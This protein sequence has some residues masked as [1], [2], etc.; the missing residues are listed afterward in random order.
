MNKMFVEKRKI[1]KSLSGPPSLLPPRLSLLA[2]I[3][4]KQSLFLFTKYVCMYLLSSFSNL[5]FFSQ[6]MLADASL[7]NYFLLTGKRKI[8][9]R[10]GFSYRLSL[11]DCQYF[12]VF[13]L[14]FFAFAF[15]LVWA[16]CFGDWQEQEPIQSLWESSETS[17]EHSPTRLSLDQLIA[18][19]LSTLFNSLMLFEDPNKTHNAM[20]SARYTPQ[21]T[22]NQFSL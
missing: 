15:R 17:L 11:G 3:G 14:L 16:G 7:C 18:H 5:F 2:P 9:F 10:I 12:F 20:T 22:R 4:P 1:I 21:E 19:F 6:N 8:W 13:C